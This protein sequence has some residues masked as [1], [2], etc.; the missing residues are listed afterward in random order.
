MLLILAAGPPLPA[1]E[2]QTPPGPVQMAE[3]L[4]D[5]MSAGEWEAAREHFDGR[6]KEALPAERL[7]QVWGQLTAAAGPF[8]RRGPSWTT[9]QGGLTTVYVPCHFERACLSAKVVFGPD[10]KVSGLWFQP[11]GAPRP[12]GPPPYADPALFDEREVTVGEGEAALPG[13]LCLPAGEG[14][15]PGLVLVHGSG[16]NDRDETVGAV[17]PFRDLAQGL[18]TRGV[19]VLRY[20]KRT[21]AHPDQAAAMLA[22]L[23]V[24]EEVIDDA[25]AAVRLLRQMPRVAPERVFV[26]GHSLGGM[27]VPRIAA[28]APEAAGFVIMAGSTRPLEELF[29]EQMD[30]IA[31]ADGSLTDL[32]RRQMREAQA[33]A[34]RIRALEP[35]DAGRT[36]VLLGAAPTYWLDLRGYDPAEAAKA[37]ERPL[38]VLHGG[39]DYQVTGKDLARWRNAL[40]GQDNATIRA[41]PALNHLFVEG[42]GPGTP[43]EY[44][45]PAHVAE[46][47]VTDLATWLKTGQ[48]PPPPE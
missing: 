30:Y 36:E 44:E 27:L 19:A 47:A 21:K 28:Q 11:G 14:P 38:L 5:S 7:K 1:A 26:L 48:L 46:K 8:Q 6:M 4:V 2:Q 3:A 31:R 42:E 9:E 25:L 29:V 39:R 33:M 13:T 22:R 41:Y 23:T 32:E 24:Q 12:P 40:E 15:F 17:K 43:I 45:R 37:V 35:S 10:G 34:E 20:E 16:P 18:A